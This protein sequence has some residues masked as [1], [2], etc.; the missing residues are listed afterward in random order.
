MLKNI[1][2]NKI[3]MIALAGAVTIL[4]GGIMS[5][6]SLQGAPLAAN[7]NVVVAEDALAL[8]GAGMGRVVEDYVGANSGSSVELLSTTA[9]GASFGDGFNEYYDA[10]GNTIGKLIVFNGE[11]AADVYNKIQGNE[12]IENGEEVAKVVGH[13]YGGDVA[14]LVK[15]QGGWYQII[16]DSVNGFVRKDGFVR[17]IEAEG[18]DGS[19]YISAAFANSDDVYLYEDPWDYSTVLCVLPSG[20]RYTLVEDGDEFSKISV[21]GVGEGWV[22]NDE[23]TFAVVRRYAALVSAEIDAANRINDGVS[24]AEDIETEKTED[25]QSYE[26]RSINIAPAAPDSEDVAALRQAIANYAQQFVG[27]LPYIWGS[28]DLSYGADCSGFTSA[29]YRAYGIEISRSSDAQ[30]WGGTSVSIDDIRPGDIVAYPGHVALYI[31]DGTVVHE[32]VP[33]TTASYASMYMM[34]IINI[35]RYIN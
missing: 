27:V 10:N 32:S 5:V 15:E 6:T 8:P 18:M 28:S 16:S 20:V 11:E 31:G 29:I 4:G 13:M 19:T 3:T 30:S 2:F 23:M 25:A 34:P 7:N 21:P 12:R 1:K 22:Y 33:G 24:A 17:G 26:R 9:L 14:T 35:A